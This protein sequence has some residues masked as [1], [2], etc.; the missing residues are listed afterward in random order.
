MEYLSQLEAKFNRLIAGLKEELSGIRTNRPTPK[1]IENIRVDYLDQSLAIKQLGT[2]GVLPPRSLTVSPWSE[3]SIP[4]ITKAID[5]ANLGVSASPQGNIIRINLPELTEE[6]RQE[7]T[8]LVRG[9][10][11]E[12]RIK[13][14]IERDEINK[15]VNQEPDKD[16]KFRAK[17]NLQ[18]LVDAFNGGVEELISLKLKEIE[19]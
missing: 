1:L 4:F 19:S 5:S 8:K 14:R 17:E 11:E 2:I 9:M 15:K 13:M 10:A 16:L 7:L 3:D 18:K 6:R 12:T